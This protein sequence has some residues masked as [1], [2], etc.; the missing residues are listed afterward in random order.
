MLR[1]D[2]KPQLEGEGITHDLQRMFDEAMQNG[3]FGGPD[4]DELSPEELWQ[5]SILVSEA[6]DV[7]E[8]LVQSY[9]GFHQYIRG[10]FFDLLRSTREGNVRAQLAQEVSATMEANGQLLVTRIGYNYGSR[11]RTIV[12]SDGRGSLTTFNPATET[13]EKALRDV[14]EL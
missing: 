14:A 13:P 9:T 12:R 10:Q 1:E 2:I 3:T 7:Q 5:L 11:T 6:T 8:R 4:L